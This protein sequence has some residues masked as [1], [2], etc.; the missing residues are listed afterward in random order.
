MDFGSGR[1][2]DCCDARAPSLSPPFVALEELQA[3][4]QNLLQIAIV[5]IQLAMYLDQFFR[6]WIFIGISPPVR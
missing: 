5:M 6:T 4:G 2:A 1:G 3:D